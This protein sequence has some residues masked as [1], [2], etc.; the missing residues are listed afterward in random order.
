[1][2]RHYVTDLSR[3]IW[4]VAAGAGFGIIAALVLHLTRGPVGPNAAK[5]VVIDTYLFMWI[6]FTLVYLLWTHLSYS[7]RD[8]AGLAA[9]TRTELKRGRRW[10]TWFLGYGG[11]SNW[12]LL[13]A[14]FAFVITLLIAQSPQHRGQGL[15]IVLGMAT[16]ACSWALMAYGFALEYLRLAM[17]PNEDEVHVQLPH[18]SEARFGDF[19]TVAILITAMGMS[20][21]AAFRTRTAWV[22]V[23]TNVILG[24][25]FNS[26]IVATLVS[27]LFGGLGR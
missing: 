27:L 8:A 20:D 15:Y 19:L 25:A 12:T 11:A 22:L 7:K 13:G 18:T 10:L 14:M 21:S 5:S 3:A 23:R 2:T 16:V 9:S 17:D 1:M 4:S 26:V 6:G 24:F